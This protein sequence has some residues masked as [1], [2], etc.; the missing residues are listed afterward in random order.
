MGQKILVVDDDPPILELLKFDLMSEGFNVVT[1]KNE[2]E[3]R[4]AVD[5]ERPALII[6]DIML[7]DKNGALI[8]NELL[9]KGLQRSTPVIFLSALASDQTPAPAAP[10]R[11]YALLGKPYDSEELIKEI[12]TMLAA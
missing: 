1:A 8:Y 11:S 4:N 9:G 2:M 3:F 12:R 10:G 5:N 7:G 6:L